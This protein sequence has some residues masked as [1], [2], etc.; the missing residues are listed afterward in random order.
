MHADFDIKNL[1]K[2][3]IRTSALTLSSYIHKHHLNLRLIT[4]RESSKIL[5]N[6]HMSNSEENK[7]L[8]FFNKCI[9]E[10]GKIL[11]DKKKV[12]PILFCHF[13]CIHIYANNLA[14]F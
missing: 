7:T 10:L 6:V 13:K 3:D 12:N 8:C 11:G 2:Y 1:R 14:N 4:N 9:K 5:Y